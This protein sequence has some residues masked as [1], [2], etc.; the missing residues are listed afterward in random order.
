MVAAHGGTHCSAKEQKQT[1]SC[2]TQECQSQI[3]PSQQNQNDC[4]DFACNTP[5]TNLPTFQSRSG[6]T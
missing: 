6:V 5:N 2:N 3:F 4:C 1:V